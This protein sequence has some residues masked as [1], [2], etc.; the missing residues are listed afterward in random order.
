MKRK[1]ILTLTI[2]ALLIAFFRTTNMAKA[3]QIIVQL[4]WTTP[5]GVYDVA[6]SADGNYLAAVNDTGLYYFDA[7]S[8]NPLWWYQPPTITLMSVAIS[9]DGG[10]VVAGDNNG[11]LHYFNQSIT[12]IDSQ[13]TPT[14]TSQDMGSAI[15]RGTLDMSANGNYTVVGGTGQNIWY[16]ADCT[17]RTG[18]DNTATWISYVGNEFYTVHISP[19]GK[20]VAG[21]GYTGVGGFVT[22][23]KDADTLT[24]YVSST[25]TSHSQLTNTI[26]DLALS[27][28]GY[29]VAAIDMELIPLTLYYWANATN[30]TGD[31]NATWTNPGF[32]SSIDISGNGDKVVAGGYEVIPSSLHFWG[33]ARTRHGT[34]TE[35]WIKLQLVSVYDIAISKDGNIIATP[36]VAQGSKYSA[37]FYLSDGTMIDN[38]TLPSFSSMVSMSDDGST[39]AMAGPEPDSLYLFKTGTDLTPPAINNVYQQPAN[40]SVTPADNVKIF[41][42]VTD[43]ESGVKRVTLNYTTGNGTWFTQTMTPYQRDIW[44]G[45]IPAFPYCTNITYIIIAEDNAN[46][47][48]T[49]QDV[50]FTLKYHVIPEF[51]PA[52]ITLLFMTTSLLSTI[53]YK[54]KRRNT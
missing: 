5:M 14:W 9:A 10:Y 46:N 25:W 37:Y 43:E 52:L 21:G 49:S 23:F 15:E 35:D 45:T 19:N 28:D 36:T 8:K 2:T 42:N 34:Q 24:G 17:K 40:D 53:V 47:T 50:G 1:I 12:R 6:V 29:A 38:Y 26:M 51:T 27:D 18:A 22:F 48:I 41:A 11:F 44:N 54:R 13:T 30:L 20:Y 7:D 4:K 39:I 32:F 3:A 16:Y 31:P 33:D